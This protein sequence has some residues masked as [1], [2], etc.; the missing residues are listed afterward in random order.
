VGVALRGTINRTDLGLTWQ[1][2][3]AAGGMLAAVRT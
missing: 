3:V 1:Q 2:K